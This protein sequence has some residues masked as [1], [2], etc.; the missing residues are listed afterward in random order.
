MIRSTLMKMMKTWTPW[1]LHALWPT[2]SS[3]D[4]ATLSLTLIVRILMAP[5]LLWLDESSP[6]AVTVGFVTDSVV[7]ML[8]KSYLNYASGLENG[9]RKKLHL[10]LRRCVRVGFVLNISSRQQRLSQR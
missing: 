1:T 8:F 6:N 2:T 4:W 10:P 9:T 7:T 5:H 3:A